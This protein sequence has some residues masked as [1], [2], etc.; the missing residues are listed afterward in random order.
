MIYIITLLACVFCSIR[1]D[2]KGRTHNKEQAYRLLMMWFIGISGFQ[3]MIGTDMESYMQW[4]QSLSLKNWS[5]QNLISDNKQYQP[6]WMA[7]CCFCRFI[8]DD[9]LL[10]KLVQATFVNIA[11]F[12][13][14]KRE[15]KYVFTAVF[16]YALMSYLVVNFN[17]M[18]QSFA[19]GF[20]LYAFS[21]LK[22]K[23]YKKYYFYVFLAYM[24]H[25]SAFILIPL[26]LLT[27]FRF[28]KRYAYTLVF[29]FLVTL[30]VLASVNLENLLI[31]ILQSGYLGDNITELGSSYMSRD[32]LGVQTDF[33]ILSIHRFLIISV[34][35]YYITKYKDVYNGSL[36]LAYILLL[37]IS[38]FLPILWRFR[39]YIDFSFYIILAQVIVESPRK[40]LQKNTLFVYLTLLFVFSY[41]P[42]REYL[43]PV[44]NSSYRNIDQYYP[45]HSIL[46]KEHD[47]RKQHFF[48]SLM[49]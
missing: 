14:F 3:Y 2:V 41:F 39:L 26:P 36:G 5:L 40:C 22:F 30:S 47:E 20:A 45:Y 17:I 31:N 35:I 49:R 21:Y 9:F 33:S 18:R 44:E 24:F 38:S 43:T 46:N 7:L 25:N 12:S 19:L 16:M 4:Y 13:F 37:I 42:F 27:Y 29:L 1:F 8:S 28:T 15:T 6:G 32:R 11:V 23:D 34:V 48:D 10:L